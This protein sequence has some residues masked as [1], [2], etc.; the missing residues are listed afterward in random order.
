VEVISL[1]HFIERYQ[2]ARTSKKNQ[3]EQSKK[4]SQKKEQVKNP[5]KQKKGG[6]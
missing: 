1:F 6:K 2:M 4:Q 5:Q 3:K